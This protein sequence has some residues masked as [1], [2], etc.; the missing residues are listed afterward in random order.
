MSLIVDS[1]QYIYPSYI[2]DYLYIDIIDTIYTVF[3]TV[4]KPLR[5]W[6]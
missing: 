3:L 1:I 6:L 4:G 2:I 5:P